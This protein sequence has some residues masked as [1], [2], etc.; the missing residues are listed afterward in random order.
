MKKNVFFRKPIKNEHHANSILKSRQ[1]FELQFYYNT[2]QFPF[3]LSKI[4]PKHKTNELCYRK[5]YAFLSCLSPL[6]P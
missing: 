2:R 1:H 5:I 3:I 4:F 6:G